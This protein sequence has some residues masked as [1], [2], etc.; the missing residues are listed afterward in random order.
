MRLL[1]SAVLTTCV[2][3][4]FTG[5]TAR[6]TAEPDAIGYH[7]RVV[8][9][10]V[11]VTIDK[12]SLATTDGRLELRDPAGAP[13]ATVPLSY[14]RNDAIHPIAA[15]V[16]ANTAI[17]TPDTDPAHA[18]PTP[19]SIRAEQIALD[20][21]SP[22]MKSALMNFATTIGI[23][24]MLGT[25]I[26]TALGVA[27]GCIGGG[28]LVGTAAAVPTIGVLAIPGFLG[29]CLVTAGTLGMTGGVIGSALIGVPAAV[30]GAFVFFDALRR[31]QSEDTPQVGAGTSAGVHGR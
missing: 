19:D 18:T 1:T 3:A 4:A 5:S 23:G 20:P 24:A 31:M 13:V 9:R 2:M 16:S 10:S 27:V 7:L 12:G 14:R 8:G 29:G 25:L 21:N 6:A 11:V 26:G 22:A 15:A 30:I 17:L 28:L